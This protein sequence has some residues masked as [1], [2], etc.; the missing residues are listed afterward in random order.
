MLLLEGNEGTT[1]LTSAHIDQLH[2]SVGSELC[3][4]TVLN[5]CDIL[6]QRLSPIRA[7]LGK[8]PAWYKI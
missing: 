5:A 6:N 2:R 8:N 1:L 7:S 4:K 3:V